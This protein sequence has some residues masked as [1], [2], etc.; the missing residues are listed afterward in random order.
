MP[1]I[2][3][4]ALIVAFWIAITGYVAYRDVWPLLFASGPPPVAIELADEAA[5]SVPVRWSI[6]MSGQKRPGRLITQMKYHEEDD[7]FT[8]TNRYSDLRHEAAGVEVVVPELTS[9]VRI[10]RSGDLR[11]QSVHG[12]LDVYWKDLKFGEATARVSG[13][14]VSGQLTATVEAE[15]S[16]AG[17]SRNQLKRTLDPVAVPSGQPLNPLQPV[18]RLTGLRPGRRW[19]VHEYDPLRDAIAVLVREQAGQY[20]LKMPEAKR[21]SLIGEVLS[22]ERILDW[23][24]QEVACW[25]I[26]YRRDE[27]V[28]RTWV[29]VSDGKVLKQEAFQKGE[30][31]SVVRDR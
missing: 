23:H 19:V 3:S 28:A 10:T 29:R 18:S 30:T 27:L 11:Q 5:Q 15:Y 21:D 16:F 8:F 26:E 14:V 4:I 2:R 24:E 6:H 22:E 25:V 20:G 12:K 31:L 7:T 13:T 1:S 17:L 9:V